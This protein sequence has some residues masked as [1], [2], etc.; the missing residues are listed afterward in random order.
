MY[1]ECTRPGR[2]SSN[3]HSQGP[4]PRRRSADRPSLKYSTWPSSKRTSQPLVLSYDITVPGYHLSWFP[5]VNNPSTREPTSKALPPTA[6]P[7]PPPPTAGP[8]TSES[9]SSRSGGGVV[10][11]RCFRSCVLRGFA[12]GDLRGLASWTKSRRDYAPF[13]V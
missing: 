5:S 7:A 10:K 1:A 4:G 2:F 3:Q 12:S 9:N 11:V 13:I 8:A 6:G